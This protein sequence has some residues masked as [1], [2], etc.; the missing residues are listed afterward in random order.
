MHNKALV[1]ASLVADSLALGAH[2]IYDT[3]KIEQAFGTI[4]SLQS[5]LPDSY[6]RTRK[7]GH[8]THYGDQTLLLLRS[9][10]NHDGFSLDSFASDWREYMQGYNGYL[11]KAS[12]ETLANLEKGMSPQQCGST[13]ADLGGAARIAP[14]VY[15]YQHHPDQLLAAV[16]EQTA[17]THNNPAVLAGAE[18]LAKIAIKVLQG[19]RPMEAVEET[20]EEGVNDLDLD[21]KIR[22]GLDS[23]GEDTKKTIKRF[24]QACVI[25]SALP[26]VIHLIATYEN[27]LVTALTENVM[28]GGDSAARG[29][30][31]GMILGAHVG[32]KAIPLEWLGDMRAYDTIMEMLEE[33]RP[34][35][36]EG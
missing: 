31:A 28:A 7:K 9:I 36:D 29:L 12:K 5:P 17:F 11:D 30:A 15:R 19:L 13:S 27:D 16:R 26:G 1:L 35:D 23:A 21:L 8:F 20:L 24:G 33:E 2:W 22:A 3:D 10:V 34:V 14:L 6:H 32:I 4:R 18:A 25:S